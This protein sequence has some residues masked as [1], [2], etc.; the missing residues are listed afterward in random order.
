MFNSGLL[1][2]YVKVPA[3][4]DTGMALE[5]LQFVTKAFYGERSFTV[6]EFYAA[7]QAGSKIDKR[8]RIHQDTTLGNNHVMVIAGEQY[9][10]G[11]T[12]SGMDKGVAI[13]DVTLEQVTTRYGLAADTEESGGG[14]GAG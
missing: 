5:V 9:A 3:K 12:Y 2:I 8:V 13:T 6:N 11:R 14:H 1:D 4:S 7:K 10:V